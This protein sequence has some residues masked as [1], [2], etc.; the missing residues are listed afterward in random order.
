MVL[1]E[2][3]LLNHAVFHLHLHPLIVHVTEHVVPQ[4][5][6]LGVATTST[7]SRQLGQKLRFKDKCDI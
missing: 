7:M 6:L 1:H 3:Q 2:L 4:L 5:G